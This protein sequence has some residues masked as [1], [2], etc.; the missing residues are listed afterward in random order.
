[1]TEDQFA[2][3]LRTVLERTRGAGDGGGTRKVSLKAFTRMTKFAK[4]DDDYKDWNCDFAVALGSKCPELSHNLKVIE[5]MPEM[6]TRSVYDLDVDRADRTGLYQLSKE[7]YEV[8]VMITEGEAK[9]MIRSVPDQD[10]ILAWHRL[11]RHC[12]RKSPSF[13]NPP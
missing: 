2:L 8:L 3:L 7:L 4:G 11:C 12:K 1:M 6:T 9:M 10:G 5:T 13:A